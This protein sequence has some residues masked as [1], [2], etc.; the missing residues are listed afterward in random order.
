MVTEKSNVRCEAVFNDERTHRFSWRRVWS[1]DKPVAAVIMLNP[2]QADDLV[3]DTTTSLVVN[4]IT[5]LE[6]FGGVE[7]LNLYSMLTQKLNFRWNSD[8]DLNAPE[9]DDFIKKAA[10]SA[11]CVIVAWGKSADTN[12]RIASRAGAVLA[13]LKPYQ[14]KVHVISDGTRDGLHPL[15]PTLRSQWILKPFDWAAYEAAE[16][17]VAE[18]AKEATQNDTGK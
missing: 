2:A 15:T 12:T 18:T 11:S 17:Q 5:R 9:N 7:V 3:M 6:R 1:K 10:E 13:L 16:A 8:E 4:N 14:G